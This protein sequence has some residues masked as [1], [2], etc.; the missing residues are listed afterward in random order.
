MLTSDCERAEAI[1][2]QIRRESAS[3][4]NIKEPGVTRV[5]GFLCGQN[6]RVL[7]VLR[8]RF[9]KASVQLGALRC[10]HK[11]KFDQT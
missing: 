3:R 5:L 6:K 2:Y 11:F 7:G 10:A 1:A 4:Q 9:Q 8:R